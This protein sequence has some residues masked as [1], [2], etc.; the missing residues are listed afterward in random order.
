MIYKVSGGYCLIDEE[1]KEFLDRFSWN[2]DCNGYI[3]TTLWNSVD[4]RFVTLR[5]HSLLMGRK[6][7]YYVDHID[8]NPANNQKSNLRHITPRENWYNSNRAEYLFQIGKLRD[9][10]FY[11]Y[12]RQ[13]V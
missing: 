1:D 3:K 10:D 7:G 8:R 12:V 11:H 13:S 9:I 5:M 4:K 2:I 6:D